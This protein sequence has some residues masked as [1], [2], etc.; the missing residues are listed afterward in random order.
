MFG[1]VSNLILTQLTK[2]QQMQT[3]TSS[4]VWEVSKQTYLSIDRVGRR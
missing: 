3:E 2:P 4:S 1:L